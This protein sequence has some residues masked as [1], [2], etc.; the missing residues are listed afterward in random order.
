MKKI[1]LTAVLAVGLAAGGWAYARGNGYSYGMI[2]NGS[3]AMMGGGGMMGGGYGSRGGGYGMMGGGGYGSRGG[4]YGMMGGGGYGS[5][6]G[7][8]GN[9]GYQGNSGYSDR[10]RT[11]QNAMT[12]EQNRRFL[13][14]TV[15]LRR[16]L[17]E[18]RFEYREAQRNP[19][20]SRQQLSK[21]E[22]EIDNLQAQLNRKAEEYR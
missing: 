7:G 11:N 17:N 6:G 16:E 18:K 14:A 9:G 22:N 12:S 21:L 8:Y 13:N 4:G 19:N 1:F 15:G 10:G 5:M 3:Y 2:G 20:T